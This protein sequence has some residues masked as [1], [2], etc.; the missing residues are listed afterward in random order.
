[1]NKALH[2]NLPSLKTNTTMEK[3]TEKAVDAIQERLTRYACN[4]SFDDLPADIVH[5][6]KVRIIDTLGAMLG[7]FSAE[8]CRITRDFAARRL[9]PD[10][11]T[12]LGTRM[13]TTP[14]MA[15]FTNATTARYAELNDIY[16][17]P[18][19]FGGHPSDT[20]TPM[21]AAAEHAH[22]DGRRFI[23]GVV[24]AFEVYTRFSDIFHNGGFDAGTFCALANAAGAGKLLGLSSDQFSHCIAMAIVPNNM[25]RQ[26]RY[27]H[28]TMWK[29][30]TAGQAGR[31]G[32]FAALLAKAGMEGP[33]LP[34]EGK[35]GWCDHVAR[36]RFALTE[37]GGKDTP[38]RIISTLIKPRPSSGPTIPSI[39]AAEKVA[40]LIN[41][42]DVQS[43]LVEVHRITM[44]F[45]ARGRHFWTPESRETADHSVPY[46]VA[47]AL[48]DGTVTLRSFD[49]AH[50]WNPQLRALMQKIEVV[51]NDEFTQAYDR[52][53]QQHRTR[54]TVVTTSGERFVGEVGTA[55]DSLG[56][57]LDD[58]K[59]AAKF[60]GLA[61]DALGT[62]RVD[63]ILEMLWNL[64]RIDDVCSIAPALV[65]L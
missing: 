6:A 30:A 65:L 51:E 32:V 44:E 54:V 4:L 19:S 48:I 55:Q 15:A 41:V 28:L 20:I 23:T 50:L 38:F 63:H 47:C 26:A 14:D 31:A 60:R 57:H 24:L 21:L 1:M 2:L 49:D 39:L 33:H 17:W 52:Q 62:K 9:M 58:A 27:S 43:I 61:E 46:V 10:G 5:A 7:G 8:P 56:Q 36:E 12:I 35:A 3:H 59:I 53:P 45:G 29:V 13:K 42:N 64:E 25:L 34:F 37:M 16:Q 40:P 11:A 22:A 18:G